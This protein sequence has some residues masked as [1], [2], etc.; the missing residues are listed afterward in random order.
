MPTALASQ[1]NDDRVMGLLAGVIYA[2]FLE[3]VEATKQAIKLRGMEFEEMG[4]ESEP[5]TIA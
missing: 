2:L 1:R 5:T 4:H 3:Y